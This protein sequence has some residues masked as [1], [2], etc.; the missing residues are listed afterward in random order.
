[1][2][3]INQK[4]KNTD[5]IYNNTNNKSNSNMYEYIITKI[6]QTK[7]HSYEYNQTRIQKTKIYHI[8]EKYVHDQCGIQ[9]IGRC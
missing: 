3:T 9:N 8:P 6:Q 7:I 5:G 4:Y 2:I 1:M